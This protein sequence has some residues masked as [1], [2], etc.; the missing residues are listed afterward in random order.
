MSIIADI[1][2][3][4]TALFAILFAVWVTLQLFKKAD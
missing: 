3:A 1:A 4:G 2:S